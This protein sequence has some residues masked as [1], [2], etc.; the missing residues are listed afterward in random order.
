MDNDDSDYQGPGLHLVGEENSKVSPVL[1][2]F[3]L[4]KFDFDVAQIRFDS[5]VENEVFLGI[6]SQEDNQWIEDFSRGSS[7]LE[8]SSGAADSCPIPRHNNVW[9]EATSSETV[10]MLLNSV[11]QEEMVPG[12][13][14]IQESNGGDELPS[15]TNQMNDKMDIVKDTHS[16]AAPVEVVGEVSETN[17]YRDKEGNGRRMSEEAQEGDLS[18][19]ASSEKISQGLTQ[20]NIQVE[21][22]C[23]ENQREECTV[24]DNSLKDHIQDDPSIPKVEI[25]DAAESV[26]DAS[27]ITE[28]VQANS[29]VPEVE[30]QNAERPVQ[31]TAPVIEKLDY[32][33]VESDLSHENATSLTDN[34]IVLHDVP[35]V[36]EKVNEASAETCAND[37]HHPV[38][39]APSEE[40]SG[41]CA[42]EFTPGDSQEPSSLTPVGNSNL[43]TMEVPF[44]EGSFADE[45]DGNRDT[46]HRKVAGPS[47]I[48]AEASVLSELQ[49]QSS[50]QGGLAI[51]Q[52]DNLS[53]S[54]MLP[55]MQQSS[56][57]VGDDSSVIPPDLKDGRDISGIHNE[58]TSAPVL[59]PAQMDVSSGGIIEEFS[60]SK[61]D[62]AHSLLIHEKVA[63]ST[64]SDSGTLEVE[65]VGPLNEGK[66]A[67]SF[68]GEVAEG[69]V[70]TIHGLESD[71]SSKSFMEPNSEG[72]GN[73]NVLPKTIENS[74]SAVTAAEDVLMHTGENQLDQV[75]QDRE[76]QI[77]T[78]AKSSLQASGDEVPQQCPDSEAKVSAVESSDNISVKDLPEVCNHSA[79]ILV[80]ETSLQT[81]NAK[82]VVSETSVDLSDNK[83]LSP[84]HPE[85]NTELKGGVEETEIPKPEEPLRE[86]DHASESQNTSGEGIGAETEK[87]NIISEEVVVGPGLSRTDTDERAGVKEDKVETLSSCNSK[88]AAT[89]M[90]SSNSMAPG[91]NVASE[92]EKSFTFDINPLAGVSGEEP[93]KPQQTTSQIK[94]QKKSMVLDG[95]PLTSGSGQTNPTVVHEISHESQK[96]PGKGASSGTRKGASERKP[97]RGSSKSG[98]ENAR[99]GNFVKETGGVQA[100]RFDMGSVERTGGKT[101]TVL[102]VPG[103]S[104]PDLNTSATVSILF[105]QPFT[106]PQQVQLRAQILV[107]GSIIQGVPP[108]EACMMSAFDGARSLWEPAWRACLERH[109]VQKS[110]PSSSGTPLQS[111]SGLKPL[112]QGKKQGSSLSKVVSTP[113]GRVSSKSTPSP[114]VTPMIPLSSPLWNI[115][116]PSGDVPSNNL[117]RGAV[118][119]YA[120][121]SPLHAYQTPNVRNFPGH[122]S[123]W[124]SQAPFP[125]S[126]VSSVQTSAA[127]VRFTSQ[128]VA[129]ISKLI[130]STEP[131]VAISS[132]VKS[133]PA[134]P[135][136]HGG[137]SGVLSG[138]S[139]LPDVAKVSVTAQPSSEKRSRKRKK[140]SVGEDLGQIAVPLPL[141]G[142]V[143]TPG[144]TK[145]APRKADVAVDVSLGVLV[146]RSDTEVASH[147][148]PTSHFSTS[149]A[150]STPSNFVLNSS[151]KSLAAISPVSSVDHTKVGNSTI[152]KSPLKAE[153]IAKVQEAK[154]QAEEAAG[155]AAIAVT[156]CQNVWCQ[157]DKHKNSGL[158]S[159]V[160]AKVASAAVVI[161]ASASIAKAAA[162]AAKIASNVALQAKLLVDE[163]LI[164]NGTQ[165]SAQADLISVPSMVNM[166]NATPASILKVGDGSNGSSSIIFAAREAARKK[167]EAASAAARHAENLE[168][169]VKAAELAA[170]AVSQAGKV[171]AMGDPLP[172]DKLVE[173]GP[174]GF[175]KGSKSPSGQGAKPNVVGNISNTNSIQELAD[176]VVGQPEIQS[177]KDARI[178]NSSPLPPEISKNLVEDPTKGIEAVS[179]SVTRSGKDLRGQKGRKPS[180]LNKTPGVA[181]ESDISRSA[182]YETAVTS[183]D[184]GGIKEGCL[185]E[186][187]KDNGDFTGAWFS[188]NVLSLKGGKASVSYT[189]LDSVDESGKL[190]EWVPLGA[191]GSK[192]P[193]IR[194]PHPMTIVLYEGARKRRRAENREYTWSIGERVDA[195]IEN[196]WREGVI[197]EKN[198]KDETTLS[199]HFPAQGKTS[200]V[201]AWHLRPTLVWKDGDWIECSNFRESLKGDTPQEK[202]LKMGSPPVES[203]GKAKLSKSIDFSETGKSEESRLLPLSAN[204]KIFNI[205]NTK[206]DKKPETL[207]TMRS[208]LQKEGSKV[209]FGV[210]KPGKKRKFMDVSKHYVSEHSSKNNVPSDSEKF[211]KYLMPQGPGSRGW[212]INSKVDPKEKQVAAESN[213]RPKGLKPGKH[214][215]LSSR[216][217]PQKNNSVA[218]SVSSLKDRTSNDDNESSQQNVSEFVSTS[219]NEEASEDETLLP[220]AAKRAAKPNARPERMRKGRLAPTVGKLAKVEVKDKSIPEAAEPRRSNRRIQPTSRLLEG[221]QSS[222]LIPKMPPVSHDKNQKNNSRGLP[223]GNEV[224]CHSSLFS[225]WTSHPLSPKR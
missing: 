143:S 36:G 39:D 181:P 28:K 9:S 84:V 11:G 186:V 79:D 89:S 204:E 77:G 71:A 14:S 40:R 31:D 7:G 167:I 212:K 22:S 46:G 69:N 201:K 43:Q 205:G 83:E 178:Q 93:K 163:T 137:G 191:D 72:L 142:T 3:S 196:G 64:L 129:E 166:G 165:K 73:G 13:P 62:D 5:L 216:A 2:P 70:G 74:P 128:P 175:L 27:A 18:A 120:T 172:I 45:K 224:F 133:T 118:L 99:K 150:V 126:L 56:I 105:Q 197:L 127:D 94:A 110:L 123:T 90:V 131:S 209:I 213:S 6:P 87:T 195:W 38:Q 155:H 25:L 140:N 168:A 92:G 222:L 170:E 190:K 125:G 218:S 174:E 154:L 122:T 157:L 29:S 61:H 44:I 158:M 76:M 10:E 96:T 78:D 202:R 51:I 159:D 35:L 68:L 41:E 32:Q 116:T 145:D 8:F 111:R 173:A 192:P 75:D 210:P 26:Q 152:G 187:F 66:V 124:P 19:G 176:A 198:K 164:S 109:H 208:G 146:S 106:D 115:S 4:P 147:P 180:S 171:V 108:D 91:V 221:L 24:G 65:L 117:V 199:I 103:S 134:N 82:Q 33:I 47:V 98:K 207:R 144:T 102:S 42:V 100:T 23:S 206:N 12:E 95:S 53:E 219:N 121:L 57:P 86:K 169:I 17:Q 200:D 54:H 193:R 81:N 101:G 149:V 50:E 184:S 52:G 151:D 156:H 220:V 153:D 112:D 59:V 97:R 162:A 225:S 20:I 85:L 48:L 113:A 130:P 80:A 148:A 21:M 104:L 223:R 136:A 107:Y 60:S 55:G 15:L 138:S 49:N 114:A 214:P 182:A 177:S 183:N 215:N 58:E 189:D 211:T 63:E 67:A 132:T 135:I 16:V 160:E 37:F 30:I 34:S 185:V 119:D 217:V 179:P 161:A 139:S 141:M 194:L 88:E 1:R 188:A 203:K